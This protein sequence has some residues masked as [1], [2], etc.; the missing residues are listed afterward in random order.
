MEAFCKT[1]DMVDLRNELNPKPV[2]LLPGDV[3]G[4]VIVA[5][6]IGPV[7]VVA[8]TVDSDVVVAVP[9]LTPPVAT[10]PNRARVC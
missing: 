1:R 7:V 5:V 10:F 9:P 2:L 4:A 6:V 3:D 8:A